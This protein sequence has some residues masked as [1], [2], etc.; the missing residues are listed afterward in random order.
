VAS[1]DELMS[2]VRV[3]YE[4]MRQEDDELWFDLPTTGERHQR[5]A[6]PGLQHAVQQRQ[7]RLG[8]AGVDGVGQV[9]RGDPAGLPQIGRDVRDTEPGA[10]KYLALNADFAKIWPNITHKKEPPADAKAWEDVPNKLEEH[11][12]PA[13]G[14]GD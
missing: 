8:P 9:P 2:Y 3:R 12:S 14:T 13:P 5:V 7:G 6:V 11:F 10:E 4:I 1:W